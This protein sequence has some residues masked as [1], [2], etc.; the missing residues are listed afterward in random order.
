MVTGK[1]FAA[2]VMFD[3][4]ACMTLAL[5]VVFEN[6]VAES[7]F[8]AFFWAVTPLAAVGYFVAPRSV[9]EYARSPQWFIGYVRGVKIAVLA[10]LAVERETVMMGAL[11]LAWIA[12]ESALRW[13][14]EQEKDHETR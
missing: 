10:L 13:C 7:V 9:R 8:K 12:F 2:I 5:W 11:I 1:K 3:V 14:I 4:A 6:T